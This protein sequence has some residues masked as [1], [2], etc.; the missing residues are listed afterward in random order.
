M[1]KNGKLARVIAVANQ[2]GGVG[3]TTT[4][5]NVGSAIARDGLKTLIVDMDPQGHV[6]LTLRKSISM[7]KATMYDF[8]M[9]P[10][11]YED[12]V[13]RY[14]ENLDV[15]PSDETL[16]EV[17]N[18]L[19]LPPDTSPIVLKNR[20]AV[21]RPL[22][23]FILIDCPPNLGFLTVNALVASTD[24]IV[25]TLASLTSYD[26]CLDLMNNVSDIVKQFNPETDIRAIVGNMVSGNTIVARAVLQLFNSKLHNLMLDE[27]IRKD[28]KIDE[29]QLVGKS[30]VDY[31]P[32]SGS[33]MDYGKLK[34]KLLEI[35]R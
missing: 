18:A 27:Y 16:R 24:I 31:K 15:L 25:P 17:E 4:V 11:R 19:D 26:G 33:S 12:V 21:I 10:G 7:N 20:L 1:V 6:Y 32:Y 2:K 13:V 5:V 30:V 29:A 23:D 14:S 28:T 34:D 3:K 8:L 9:D 35:C 22:Y